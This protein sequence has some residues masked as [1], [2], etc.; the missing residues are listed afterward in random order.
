LIKGGKSIQGDVALIIKHYAIKTCNKKELIDFI[1]YFISNSNNIIKETIALAYSLLLSDNIINTIKPLKRLVKN[2]NSSIRKAVCNAIIENINN[3]AEKEYRDA[4]WI[5]I[6]SK[7]TRGI[8]FALLSIKNN[9]DKF[10]EEEIYLILKQVARNPR[11]TI[12]K[13]T[14]DLLNTIADKI[15]STIIVEFF[16]DLSNSIYGG[17]EIIKSIKTL[18]KT[19]I[20]LN[21]NKEKIVKVIERSSLPRMEKEELLEILKKLINQS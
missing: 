18:L 15:D 13:A 1:N 20:M 14:I 8:K 7:W 21:F 4:I 19:M 12:I 9:L 17:K 6:K 2:P 10:T 3:I 16:S 11:I 5:L